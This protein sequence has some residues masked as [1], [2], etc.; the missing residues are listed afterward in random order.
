MKKTL[1]VIIITFTLY[2]LTMKNLFASVYADTYGFSAKGISMGNAMTAVVD[3]WSSVFYNMSGLGKTRMSASS[4]TGEAM[5]LV[6]AAKSQS[7]LGKKVL[8]ERS[9]ISSAEEAMPMP[10][11]QLAISYFYSQPLFHIDIER[12]DDLGNPLET[13]GAEDLG[14]GAILLGVAF[15]LNTL[16]T[17]PKVISSARL[18]IGLGSVQGGYAQKMNDIDL[19]THNFLRYG[20]EAQKTMIMVGVGMGFFDDTF[21]LGA[22]ANV[23]FAGQGNTMIS[24]TEVGPSE[25]TPMIQ[26]QMDLK[27]SPMP[28]AGLYVKPGKIFS[29][30][31]G[32]QI[33]AA[34]RHE[35]YVEID[36][37]ATRNQLKVGTATMDLK[38]ALLDF[39]T[40][41]IFS[42]GIA[43]DF[44][45]TG[46]PFLRGL[47]ISLDVQYEMWSKFRVSS[48]I[49]SLY[50]KLVEEEA[51]GEDY[52]LIELSDI[53]VPRV[54]ISYEVYGWLTVY[55]G[56]YYQPSFVPDEAVAGAINYL[57]NN[58]HVFSCGLTIAVPRTSVIKGLVEITVAF[59]AQLL[60]EREITKRN[61]TT[62]NPDYSYG[63]WNP[64][65]IIEVSM[66]F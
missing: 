39:Y 29:A 28:V 46:I 32:L 65:G 45:S 43:Y 7:L 54:G 33:G 50:E 56:Y 23:T 51:L 64:S 37:F 18:G 26:N 62:Y 20:R 60:E 31:E 44:R 3:D 5:K 40:P 16:F 61:P 15:D 63:G 4:A 2:A 34:Y 47:T 1:I 58:R 25:Q 41:Y 30:L 21:G 27:T 19:R 55:S 38:L 59:Q 9:G 36:P 8:S 12:F 6:P 13:K 17:L 52:L 57:D 14:M 66:R 22:G 11:H 10:T 35:T 48:A 42:A 24:G 49:E 53:I